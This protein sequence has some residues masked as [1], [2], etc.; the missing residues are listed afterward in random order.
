MRTDTIKI[1]LIIAVALLA[2]CK[3]QSFYKDLNS[4]EIE[5][6]E[7][8]TPILN[9]RTIHPLTLTNQILKNE[10][11]F[12][13]DI[14]EVRMNAKKAPS[15]FYKDISEVFPSKSDF[16]TLQK[17]MEIPVRLSKYNLQLNF[18]E[19]NENN[20]RMSKP[21]FNERNGFIYVFFDNNPAWSTKELNLRVYEK[22]GSKYRNVGVLLWSHK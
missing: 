3:S 5:F 11:D 13:W 17:E 19:N 7:Y 9:N 4:Q 14:D 1:F 15:I 2:S 21:L 6:L 18:S 12:N 10:Y 22:M 16:L 8:L 20:Y